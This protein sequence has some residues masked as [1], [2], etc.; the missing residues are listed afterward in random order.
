MLDGF[1]T[2]IGSD[3]GCNAAFGGRM[4]NSVLPRK[5]SLPA[6]CVHRYG[7]LQEYDFAGPTGVREDQ[8]QF[9]VYGD[10]AD[11]TQTA[12][13]ALRALIVPYTGTLSSGTVV[14][15]CYLERD[16]DMPFL[17]NADTKGIAYRST[18]G[19]RVVSTR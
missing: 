13:E 19:F 15:A 1:I 9:D 8:I 14:Q 6:G 10:T 4:Y 5:Y 12:C 3:S 16:M 18:L 17:P 11:D 2:L 7:G